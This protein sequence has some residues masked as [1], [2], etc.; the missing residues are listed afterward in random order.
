MSRLHS[1]PPVRRGWASVP[2]GILSVDKGHHRRQRSVHV[3]QT[4]TIHPT[5]NL[6]AEAIPRFHGCYN[7]GNHSLLPRSARDDQRR[8]T[9]S[10]TQFQEGL[11]HP[12]RISFCR[13]DKLSWRRS[14]QL[15]VSSPSPRKSRIAW[16]N[17]RKWWQID[18]PRGTVL[19][20]LPLTLEVERQQPQKRLL[21]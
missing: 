11:W 1:V 20:G 9:P 5:T 19:T 3:P 2:E 12:G 16:R 18:R 10:E 7:R 4:N 8:G 13:A 17:L 14:G 21:V 15:V 6:C